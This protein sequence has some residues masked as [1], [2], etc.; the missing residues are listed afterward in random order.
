MSYYIYI[1]FF[2]LKLNQLII[3]QSLC[4]VCVSQLL[5]T[6]FANNLYFAFNRI[7]SYMCKNFF[8]FQLTV[9]IDLVE[10]VYYLKQAFHLLYDKSVTQAEALF[11][12]SLIL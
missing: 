10:V 11:Y 4:S 6:Y 9:K 8:S 7:D 5:E 3:Y 12:F 1:Y 2:T